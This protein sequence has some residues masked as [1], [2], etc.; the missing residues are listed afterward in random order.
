MDELID[1]TAN[2]FVPEMLVDYIDKH[3]QQGKDGIEPASFFLNGVCLLVD[4]SG[5]TKLSGE[6]CNLGKG[7]IDEL[8]LAT[9]G[10]MGKLVE[11]IYTYGGEII[12]FAGDAIICIFS[13]NFITEVEIKKKNGKLRRSVY[14]FQC[15]W[16][17]VCY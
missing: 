5:F 3:L 10:Y 1:D 8:Q 6:F 2:C 4:I 13:S 11:I 12:K 17:Q 9:N 16:Q 7:G 15:L 14:D